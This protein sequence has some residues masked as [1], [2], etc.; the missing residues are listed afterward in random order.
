MTSNISRAVLI[1]PLI[2]VCH[3]VEESPWF[4]EW[5]N[6]HVPRGITSGAF[7][8]VNLTALMITVTIVA[9]EYFSRS[10]V[11]LTLLIGWL[12]FLMGANALFH[13]LA[14]IVDRGYVPGL[15]TAVLLYIPYYVWLFAS[16]VKSR[17]SSVPVLFTAAGL[18]SIPM[19]TH[20]Y[21]IVFQG[22]R[23]F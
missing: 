22:D 1:A 18:C 3:F 16:A 7:W 14:S 12:G 20:G 2:F 5:F 10:G 17:R 9:I 19:L 21:L 11:S 23:L 8:R 6:A 13:V 15:V 4:V